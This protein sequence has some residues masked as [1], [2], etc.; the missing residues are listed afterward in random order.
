MNWHS[1]KWTIVR[2]LRLKRT[3]QDL[4]EEVRA[5]L[6][7][8]ASQRI[9]AGDTSEVARINAARDFGNLTLVKEVTR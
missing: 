9:D 2:L 5:H 6:A 8:D 3:E 7:M 1:W 4:D